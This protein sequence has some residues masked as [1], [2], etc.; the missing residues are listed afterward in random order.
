MTGGSQ[1]NEKQIDGDE[2]ERATHILLAHSVPVD[3]HTEH[4]TRMKLQ[5]KFVEEG[6]HGNENPQHL[7]SSGRTAC[8]GSYGHNG[9]RGTPEGCTPADIV[10]LLGSK[11]CAAHDGRHMEERRAECL[12]HSMWQEFRRTAV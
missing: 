2:G 12:L 9:N 10:E 1:G 11:A 8:T 6:F 7:D 3:S 5:Y 4:G